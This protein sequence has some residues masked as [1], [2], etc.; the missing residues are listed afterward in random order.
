M[1]KK[2]KVV[3]KR[4]KGGAAIQR[5]GSWRESLDGWELESIER[6]CGKFGDLVRGAASEAL[7][8]AFGDDDTYVAWPSDEETFDPL[9]M[10]LTLA[11]QASEA[12]IQGPVFAFSLKDAVKSELEMCDEDDE[13]RARLVLLRDALRAWAEEID[14]AV[15]GG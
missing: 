13:V 3:A 6:A 9:R 14:A 12:G 11:L 15:E 10:S 4:R 2:A 1:K 8:L 5:V 7:T